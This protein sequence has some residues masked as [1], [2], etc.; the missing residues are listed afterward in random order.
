LFSIFEVIRTPVA[1]LGSGCG[2]FDTED[3]QFETQFDTLNI[4][5]SRTL[6][7]R[8]NNQREEIRQ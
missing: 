7:M 6:S 8:Q 4:F 3:L 2:N 1:T 5:V